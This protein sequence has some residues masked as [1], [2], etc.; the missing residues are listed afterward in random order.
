LSNSQARARLS[1]DG[2][3]GLGGLRAIERPVEAGEDG[4]T[5]HLENLPSAGE[6][7]SQLASERSMATRNHIVEHWR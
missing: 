7:P 6:L 1:Y 2:P 4:L 5:D 3:V